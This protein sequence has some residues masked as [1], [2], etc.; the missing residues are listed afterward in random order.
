MVGEFKEACVKF[1]CDIVVTNFK[2]KR[3]KEIGRERK[4][5]PAFGLST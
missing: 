1:S 3:V 2:K 4:L 5:F